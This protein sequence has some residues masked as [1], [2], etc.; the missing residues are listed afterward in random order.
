MASDAAMRALGQWTALPQT[1]P[2]TVEGKHSSTIPSFQDE[3]FT[4][5]ASTGKHLQARTER[6]LAGFLG[7]LTLKDWSPSH[8]LTPG[9]RALAGSLE[10]GA[11][12]AAAGGA[13]PAGP[14]DQPGRCGPGAAAPRA[15]GLTWPPGRG[16]CPFSVSTP[17][18][19]RP[20]LLR[21]TAG[22]DSRRPARLFSPARCIAPTSVPF[23]RARKPTQIKRSCGWEGGLIIII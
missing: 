5:G 22:H 19:A 10:A 16:C 2:Y 21:G 14:G 11:C 8:L 12:T 3:L 23:G 7:K 1:T 15:A 18:T 20:P 4:Q 6:L 9:R 13:S 17:S